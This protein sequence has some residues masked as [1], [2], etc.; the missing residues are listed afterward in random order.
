[1]DL[2]FFIVARLSEGEIQR[3]ERPSTTPWKKE[4][5]VFYTPDPMIGR[6]IS[7]LNIIDT[8]LQTLTD[9]PLLEAAMAVRSACC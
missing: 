1:L 6:F 5:P 4:N 9:K 8:F 3:L 7:R 2:P